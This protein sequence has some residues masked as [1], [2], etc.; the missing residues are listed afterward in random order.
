MRECATSSFLSIFFF[1]KIQ[2]NRKVVQ[3]AVAD[4]VLGVGRRARGLR[5]VGQ[6]LDLQSKQ[7]KKKKKKMWVDLKMN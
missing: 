1:P 2:T 4:A 5:E 7:Q 3:K 6:E